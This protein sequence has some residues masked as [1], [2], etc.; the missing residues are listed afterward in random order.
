MRVCLFVYVSVCIWE[1]SIIST[2][3]KLK[4]GE[5]EYIHI[6]REIHNDSLHDKIASE[7]IPK[8]CIL[9]KR[10]NIILFSK[11]KW[12]NCSNF[13]IV[14]GIWGQVFRLPQVRGKLVQFSHVQLCILF[15]LILDIGRCTQA[16]IYV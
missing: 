3:I 10:S 13:R 12:S 8:P 7:K 11:K 6:F 4:L 9:Y 2:P 1:I 14:W 5:I 16:R 15:Q